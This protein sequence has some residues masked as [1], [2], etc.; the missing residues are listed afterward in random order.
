M[1]IFRQVFWS[2]NHQFNHGPVVCLI[3]GCI[4]FPDYQAS[5]SHQCDLEPVVYWYIVSDF[6]I[7]GIHINMSTIWPWTC[8]S[9]IHCIWFPDFG[10]SHNHW[11]GVTISLLFTNTLYL[12]SRFWGTHIT[13]STVWP[14]THYL[15]ILCVSGVQIFRSDKRDSEPGHPVSPSQQVQW[16]EGLQPFQALQHPLC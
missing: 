4:W 7:F 6:Q 3:I 2:Q 16:H 5:Y 9:L 10:D 14:W 1:W 15:P 12:I 13:I 8:C 11:Y